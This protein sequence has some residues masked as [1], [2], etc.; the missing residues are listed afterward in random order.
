MVSEG[1]EIDVNDFGVCKLNEKGKHT[2]YLVEEE[3]D[4]INWYVNYNDRSDTVLL[5]RKVDFIK[6]R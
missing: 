6:E 1:D 4:S 3:D 5:S 2:V